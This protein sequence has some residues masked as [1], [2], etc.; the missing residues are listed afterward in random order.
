MTAVLLPTIHQK[1]NHASL[2]QIF[3]FSILRNFFGSWSNQETQ[4]YLHP[5]SLIHVL[6]INIVL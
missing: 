5:G 2:A 3:G 4:K 1:I 6:Y